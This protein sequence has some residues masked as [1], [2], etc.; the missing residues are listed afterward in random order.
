[1]YFQMCMCLEK[2]VYISLLKEINNR[3][4]KNKIKM[5]KHQKRRNKKHKRKKKMRNG[6]WKKENQENRKR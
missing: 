6:K 5:K 3:K 2:N 1:M 4:T